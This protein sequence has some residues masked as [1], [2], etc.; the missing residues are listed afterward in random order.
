MEVEVEE[1]EEEEIFDVIINGKEY[2]TN[3]ESNGTIYTIGKDEN[4]VEVGTFV[5]GKAVFR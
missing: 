3:N 1:G 5:N 2:Y 4:T